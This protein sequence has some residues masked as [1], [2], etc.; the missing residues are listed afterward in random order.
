METEIIPTDAEDVLERALKVL[1]SGG[2]V[3]FPT[4][5]VYGLAA[6]VRDLQ[7]IE[8]IYQVKR[9]EVSRPIALLLSD[10]DDLSDVAELPPKAEPLVARFW[11]GGL[12]LILPKTEI[13]PRKVSRDP[14]V[15]VRVPNLTFARELIRAAGGRLAVTSANRS[16][17]PSALTAQEVM[18][19]LG[20]E[21]ELVLDG[22]R[23]RGG[24]PST[25]ID[26]TV[27]P[28]AILR[29]GAVPEEAIRKMLQRVASSRS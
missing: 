29:R 1:R 17:S 12:T 9:R 22:G 7:A 19:Q 11:P 14:T 23:C 10:A 28:P 5:T 25:V 24:I 8:R 2:L 3:A 20:G 26:C 4:D 27:W 15:G 16:G 21:I 18:D 6:M 13:V